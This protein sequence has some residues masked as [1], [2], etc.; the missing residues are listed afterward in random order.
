MSAGDILAH[1]FIIHVNTIVPCSYISSKW[2]LRF[3]YS[4]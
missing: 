2:C 1:N 4:G 3:M